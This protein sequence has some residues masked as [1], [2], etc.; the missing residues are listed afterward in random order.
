[1][2]R[3]PSVGQRGA[4]AAAGPRT[5]SGRAV[6]TRLR[7][8]RATTVTAGLACYG[9]G[10]SCNTAKSLGAFCS[11]A[12]GAAPKCPHDTYAAASERDRDPLDRLRAAE[13]TARQDLASWPVV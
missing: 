3:R 5:S 7:S 11:V 9:W 8:Q 1:M 12:A 4:A 10:N 6:T 2:R 13:R